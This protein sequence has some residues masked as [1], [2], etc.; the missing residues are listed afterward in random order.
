MIMVKLKSK[1]LKYLSAMKK[2]IF[3]PKQRN[4]TKKR[5][6]KLFKRAGFNSIH[7]SGFDNGFYISKL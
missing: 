1:S 4:T 3:I 6:I 7:Y 5:Q 2:R